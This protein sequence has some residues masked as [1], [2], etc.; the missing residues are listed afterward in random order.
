MTERAL[1]LVV[2]LVMGG[3]SCF[4]GREFE[5]W[6][7]ILDGHFFTYL[8]VVKFEITNTLNESYETVTR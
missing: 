7:C 4:K 6:H 8:F 2:M 5:S 3:D 1:V